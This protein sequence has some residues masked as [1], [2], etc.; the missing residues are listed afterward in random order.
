MNYQNEGANLCNMTKALGSI[1]NCKIVGLNVVLQNFVLDM[2]CRK[3]INIIHMKK[4][5]QNLLI[6]F[7]NQA[8]VEKYNCVMWFKACQDSRMVSF[9][10][11]MRMKIILDLCSYLDYSTFEISSIFLR[12][13]LNI[14]I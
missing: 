4:N 11:N 5:L 12:I 6:V 3:P 7:I 13:F 2:Q 8:Q 1:I 9:K 10:L 14:E